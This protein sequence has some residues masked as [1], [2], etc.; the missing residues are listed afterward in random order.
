MQR[1]LPQSP[2]VREV[3]SSLLRRGLFLFRRDVRARVEPDGS[4]SWVYSGAARRAIF[5]REAAETFKIQSGVRIAAR[6]QDVTVRASPTSVQY[7]PR[8]PDRVQASHSVTL[9]AGECPGWVRSA[10]IVNKGDAARVRVVTLHDPT[11]LNYRRDRDPPGEIGVNAFNRH[12]QV[13]MDDVGDTTGVRVVAFSPRPSVIYMTKDRARAAELLSLGELPENSLGLSGPVI[14]MTQ[15]DFDLPPGAAAEVTSVSVYHPSSLESALSAAASRPPDPQPPALEFS[16]SSPSVNFTLEWAK[17]ALFALEAEASLTERLWCGVAMAILRGDAFQAMAESVRRALRK[18]GTVAYWDG[19]AGAERAE[20]PGP[21]ETSLHLIALSAFLCKSRD[22]KLLRRWYPHVRRVADGLASL[23]KDGLVS[24]PTDSPDG[25][26][27]RL[28]SGYPSGQTSEVNLMAVRALRD[29][30][31]VAFLASKGGDSARFRELSVRVLAAL[32]ERLRD[33]ESGSLAL[34]V[35]RRGVAH[36]ETTIDQAVG[37]SYFSPD[38]NLASSTVH[39]MLEKDFETGYGPRTVPASN[40]LYF[41]PSYGDG[42]LG[43]Y[44]TRAAL[45]HAALAYASGYP[46]IGSAQ[47]EKVARLV[48][49]DAERLGGVPGELPYWLDTERRQVAAAG[50]DPVA[51]ARFVESVVFGEAGLS[52][53]S[54]GPRFRLPEASQLRWMLFHRLDLG[55]KGT[56]F[57]GRSAGRAF[58]VTTFDREIFEERTRV[59]ELGLATALSRLPECERI[60]GPGVEGALFWDGACSYVCLGNPSGSPYSGTVAVPTR[61]KAFSTALFAQVEEL[62]QETGLWAAVERVK[63]VGRVELK[64][65]LRAGSWK[66][67][68]LSRAGA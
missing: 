66:A 24:S 31:A 41:S 1:E 6:S 57:V 38:Q 25:W 50:T 58:V 43:G 13:V 56:V 46:S 12:D 51:A 64:V 42:Q 34:N 60:G 40:N 53:D 4:S 37:L 65:E 47:L 36:K 10:R 59:G 44:W 54:R 14:L 5:G 68:R 49:A 8:G 67:F 22:K 48:Y 11:A 2:P 61:S 7:L 16:S 55:K 32:N 35:D 29:A 23:A 18:D 20:R 63:L 39:R 26:R 62:Q 28:G 19:A 15:H 3:S 52:V 45:A 30:S 33:S 21:V 17:A 27:R 9:L